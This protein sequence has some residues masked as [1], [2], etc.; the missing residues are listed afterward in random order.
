MRVRYQFRFKKML[1]IGNFLA[2]D[3]GSRTYAVY[4]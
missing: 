2:K 1:Y 3:V 4:D